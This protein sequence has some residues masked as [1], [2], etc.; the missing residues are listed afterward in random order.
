MQLFRRQVLALLQVEF[1]QGLVH[2]D[3]LVDDAAMGL[4]DAGEVGRGAAGL[5]E[6]VHDPL[7]AVGGQVDGQALGAE[8]VAD[9]RGEASEVNPLGVDLVDDDDPA[10]LA[11]LGRGHHAL[12]HA[13]DAGLGADDHSGR[14]HRWQD[15]QAAADE[16]GKAGGVEQIDVLAVGVE[17]GDADV[18]GVFVLLLQGVE[19][20]NGR[21][22]GHAARRGDHAR[23]GEQG[24]HQGGLAGTGVTYQG[25]V[26]D[27]LGIVVRH[28][29]NLPSR[30]RGW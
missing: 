15:G 18:Q 23:G 16:V 22:A 20:T 26:A 4:L 28:G 5:K 27:V 30:V 13:L 14:L 25:D 9:L 7:A 29:A 17:A 2:L 11:L 3:H 10:Q 21:P 19:V 12:S 6:T 1:H 24:L 8:G